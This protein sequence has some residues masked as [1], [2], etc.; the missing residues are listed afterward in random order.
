[1][2]WAS[3]I[4]NGTVFQCYDQ[5]MPGNTRPSTFIVAIF[6]I[7]GTQKTTELNKIS[8]KK[9]LDPLQ[10]NPNT[11]LAPNIPSMTQ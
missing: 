7:M 4:V 11:A 1:M 8:V 2:K 10:L 9:G 3:K 6:I 5:V